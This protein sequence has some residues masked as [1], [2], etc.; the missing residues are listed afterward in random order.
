MR[1]IV[2]MHQPNYLPWI[3]LFSKIQKADCFIISDTYQCADITR[4][5]K[6][7]T[8]N[9]SG[10]LTIPIGRKFYK[11]R[12][13]DT[14]LPHENKW[15]E[16]HW[17][18]ICHN[19]ARAP[20][21]QDYGD[22]FKTLFQKDFKYLWQINTEII[23]F[24][25]ECFKIDV[26]IVK[27]TDLNLSS[28]L[29]GTDL[30]LSEVRSVGGMTYL[31]GPSGSDYLDLGKFYNSNLDLKFFRFEHPFYKQRYP[32]FVPNLSAID[33]LF[34]MGSTSGDIIRKSGYIEDK[35]LDH[36]HESAKNRIF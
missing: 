3:G 33:L 10:Y 20:Y 13:C 29:V 7:R 28:T 11:S 19:Y 15:R 16:L 4:R 22:F 32:G 30:I 18:Q 14:L 27:T 36:P 5:N 31:S 2:T 12:I 23:L 17:Q 9:G 8:N 26:E 25:L 1:R 24:L 21:F 34:N 35:L 6:I